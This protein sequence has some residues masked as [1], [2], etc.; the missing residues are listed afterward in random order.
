LCLEE[1]HQKRSI[2]RDTSEE[3]SIGLL[4][5]HNYSVDRHKHVNYYH[6][7]KRS[8][9]KGPSNDGADWMRRFP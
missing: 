8:M 4:D 3:V 1:V 9:R 7:Q 5:V 6:Y 2:R